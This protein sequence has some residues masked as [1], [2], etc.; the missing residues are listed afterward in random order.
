ML[1]SLCGGNSIKPKSAKSKFTY[2]FDQWCS[3]FSKPVY[4]KLLN[5]EF[6]AHFYKSLYSSLKILVFTYF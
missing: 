2:N 6:C 3:T 5:Y 1:L 4:T